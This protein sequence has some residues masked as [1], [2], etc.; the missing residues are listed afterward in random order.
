MEAI[1]Q[2]PDVGLG[3]RAGRWLSARNEERQSR[4]AREALEAR[5][6]YNRAVRLANE[7][8]DRRSR[9][10]DDLG[11]AAAALVRGVGGEEDVLAVEAEIDAAE[12]DRRRYRAA[13][14]ELAN[15]AG[16]ITDSQGAVLNR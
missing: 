4:E 3:Q 1:G 14:E 6:A 7:A 8:A 11:I 12:R 5:P 2:D 16:I 13:A 15:Q 9:L 10:L